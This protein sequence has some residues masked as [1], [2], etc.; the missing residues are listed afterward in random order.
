LLLDSKLTGANGLPLT[1]GGAVR[2][3]NVLNDYTGTTTL[4]N[5]TLIIN[6]PTQLGADVSSV[7]VTGSASRGFG[8]GSLLLEGG[9]DS[10]M[11]FTRDLTIQGY[12]P[13]ADRGFAVVS[14][15]TNTISGDIQY[16][17]G[18][19]ATGIHSAGGLLTISGD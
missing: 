13:I 2:L 9:Y 14:V 11:N 17:A 18:N 10:G 6:N 3:S 4:S 12:G 7:V 16:G 5:G 8:G 1:G 15:G 19:V